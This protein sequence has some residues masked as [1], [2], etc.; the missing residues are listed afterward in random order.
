MPE[1]QRHVP[2]ASAHVEHPQGG[3]GP[4]PRRGT[5]RP[6]LPRGHRAQ[7]TQA[8]TQAHAGVGQEA[9]RCRERPSWPQ[10]DPL[11]AP[12]SA[13]GED[14]SRS[15]ARAGRR[16]PT[17]S[18]ALERAFVKVAKTYGQ[19][20]GIEYNAWR[21]AGVERRGPRSAPTSPARRRT[22]PN[23]QEVARQP[24]G[25]RPARGRAG[26]RPPRATRAVPSRRSTTSWRHR[27]V[28]DAA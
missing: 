10:A 14:R 17:T 23:R 21:A 24:R 27:P 13:P 11:H 22:A 16:R 6:P 28:R 18:A 25:V 12:P 7:P 19:R 8:G 1:A 20:K 9:P 4:G 5:R 2:T 3:A 26:W 15:R